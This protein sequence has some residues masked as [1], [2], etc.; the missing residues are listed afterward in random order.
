M[1]KRGCFNPAPGRFAGG[2]PTLSDD[3]GTERK[4]RDLSAGGADCLALTDSHSVMA[5]PA[6]RASGSG[7]EVRWAVA[8]AEVA[9]AR[10]A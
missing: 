5:C 6:P 3:R 4:P 10:G 8:C 1:L 2:S 9:R 7:R